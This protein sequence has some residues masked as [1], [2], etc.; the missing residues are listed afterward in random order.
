MK[1]IVLALAPFIVLYALAIF[2]P[3]AHAGTATATLNV[4]TTVDASCSLTTTSIIFPDYSPISQTNDVSA[5]TVVLTCTTGTSATIALDTGLH[6]VG[7]QRN[8]ADGP[9]ALRYS[10]F[11]DAAHSVLW[12]TGSS[13]LTT[14]AAPDNNPRTYTVYGLIPTNQAVPPGS[15]ADTVVATVNF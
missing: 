2:S 10:L 9:D 3:Q 1:K 7:S 13:A 6:N 11:Q 8:L 12:L 5:G 4:S 14:T 15:Y